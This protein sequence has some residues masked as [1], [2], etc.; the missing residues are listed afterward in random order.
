[1][2][3]VGPQETWVHEAGDGAAPRH[4]ALP[5]WSKVPRCSHN[6]ILHACIACSDDCTC[7]MQ[8]AYTEPQE[9]TRGLTHEGMYRLLN[10]PNAAKYSSALVYGT[11]KPQGVQFMQA[12]AGEH[13]AACKPCCSSPMLQGRGPIS[14]RLPASRNNRLYL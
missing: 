12:R 2:G 11:H 14:R 6:I 8:S 13:A 7:T 9:S 4:G 5:Q 10:P 1:M 3:R